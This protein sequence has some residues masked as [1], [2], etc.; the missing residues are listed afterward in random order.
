MLDVEH[1]N[2]RLYES[3]GPSSPEDA[4][5]SGREPWETHTTTYRQGGW[6][7]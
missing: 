3:E 5:Q 4:E 6:L 7:H 2:T 1:F